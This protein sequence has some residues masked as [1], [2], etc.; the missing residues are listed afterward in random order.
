M[1]HYVIVCVQVDACGTKFVHLFGNLCSWDDGWAG[2]W[3]TDGLP[4]SGIKLD[5]FCCCLFKCTPLWS[6]DHSSEEKY[7]SVTPQD[8]PP[9]VSTKEDTSDSSSPESGVAEESPAESSQDAT[10]PEGTCCLTCIKV[11]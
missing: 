2:R 5:S 9:T 8:A 3:I 10:T 11:V 6:Q 7:A 4:S 1:V